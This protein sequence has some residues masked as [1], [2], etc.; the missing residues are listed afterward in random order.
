MDL[1]VGFKYFFFH[2]YY[3]G[4]FQFHEHILRGVETTNQKMSEKRQFV[5][6]ETTCFALVIQA[7]LL[8]MGMEL[9]HY[10]FRR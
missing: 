7:H 9:K 3:L 10:V 1:D 4:N 8:R 5:L 2:P 6:K